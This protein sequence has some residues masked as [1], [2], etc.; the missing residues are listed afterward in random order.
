MSKCKEIRLMVGPPGVGKSTYINKCIENLTKEKYATTVIS[1]DVIRQVLTGGAT[2]NQYFSKENKVFEEFVNTA[3]LAIK[4]NI[5]VIF[6]DATH[7]NAGS[8]KKIL[9]RLEN[10]E[11]YTLIATIFKVPLDVALERNSHRTGFALVPEDAIKNMYKSFTIPTS[12]ELKKYNFKNLEF[13]EI[14]T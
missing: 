12:A 5:E 2:G 6:L 13:V 10:I 9:S 8:R 7:L 3:N 11:D 1:R 14:D 4:S